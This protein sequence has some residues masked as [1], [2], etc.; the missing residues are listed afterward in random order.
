MR[1]RERDLGEKFSGVRRAKDGPQDERRRTGRKEKKKQE[2]TTDGDTKREKRERTRLT[3]P[4]RQGGRDNR[5]KKTHLPLSRGRMIPR[6]ELGEIYEK[7]KGT[8]AMS[9]NI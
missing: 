2:E 3:R 7:E 9:L 6:V 8:A 5:G 4:Q 1:T